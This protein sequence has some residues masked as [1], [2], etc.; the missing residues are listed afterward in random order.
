MMGGESRGTASRPAARRQG[1][2][3]TN[4]GDIAT[5]VGSIG[6]VATLGFTAYT[7]RRHID[8]ERQ[9]DDERRRQQ[10]RLVRISLTDAGDVA[11]LVNDSAENIYRVRVLVKN[12]DSGERYS[13]SELSEIVA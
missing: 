12:K 2:I 5:W 4:W 3:L 7:L 13:E 10:A 1:A 11:T 6:T 8:R 9:N